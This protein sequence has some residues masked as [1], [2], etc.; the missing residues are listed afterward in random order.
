MTPSPLVV[1]ERTNLEDAARFTFIPFP[2]MIV[3]VRCYAVQFICSWHDIL[4]VQFMINLLQWHFRGVIGDIMCSVRSF[5]L[6]DYFLNPVGEPK[7][8]YIQCLI[9][10]AIGYINGICTRKCTDLYTLP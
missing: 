9:T 10:W 8:V 4:L 6:F 5:Y 3:Y 2:N 1:R 7:Q